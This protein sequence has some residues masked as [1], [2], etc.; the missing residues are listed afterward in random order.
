MPNNL[1]I[2]ID[3]NI[4][5]HLEDYAAVRED[6][7]ELYRLCQKHKIDIFI[8][9]RA[10]E[11]INRD[12]DIQR[13]EVTLSKLKKYQVLKNSPVNKS[14]L[15]KLFGK[16]SSENDAV[17]TA[18]L[19]S[20]HI[21]AISILITEDKG[22]LK[23]GA[24]CEKPLSCY[25]VAQALDLIRTLKEPVSVKYPYVEERNCYELQ[26]SEPFF[27]SLRLDY[28][29]FSNWSN[30]CISERRTCWVIWDSEKIAALAI[31]KDE[32]TEDVKELNV[33]GNKILK[34]CTFKVAESAR[35]E[36]Y[37]EQLLKQAM[38]YCFRNKYDSLYL[39]TYPHQV[40]L[41]NTL[42]KFGF[43]QASDKNG[44]Q[45]YYKWAGQ[46]AK[47][48]VK[49]LQEFDFHKR[50]WPQVK[51]SSTTKVH[52]IPIKPQYHQRIFPEYQSDLTG[53]QLYLDLLKQVESKT[54]GNAIRK[55]YISKARYTKLTRGDVILF[56]KSEESIITT[57]G[58]VERVD[59]EA[60]LTALMMLA[61]N[62]T[63]YSEQE[64]T[65]TL[66]E[67][68]AALVINFYFSFH[69][70]KPISL[71]EAKRSNILKGAPQ[72]PMELH[73]ESFQNL[74]ALISPRCQEIF[75]YA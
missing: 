45:V 15:E 32:G 35:G 30:K 56:Y 14:E 21:G 16:I 26:F 65:T 47:D 57:V 43:Q 54:P 39:T 11:D 69:L 40:T 37:G 61:G 74:Q 53:Q 73:I 29:D 19:F 8:H 25:T 13:R 52:V 17:D 28:S 55:V 23:R 1:S 5:I 67:R 64:L 7:S 58:V 3:T 72:G 66:S 36:R 63:V 2:L 62:R 70:D 60:N 34:L 75:N 24:N 51:M 71:D 68:G 9:E 20:L 49:I 31:K 41:I 42:E 27:D 10:F 4:I 12:S 46:V 6:Y 38:D 59:F 18:Q 44:E 48:D 50:F 33:P 22:I